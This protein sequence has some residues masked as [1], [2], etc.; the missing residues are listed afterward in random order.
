MTTNVYL[1]NV[2]MRQTS[3]LFLNPF[4]NSKMNFFEKV[5]LE[6]SIKH[7]IRNNGFFGGWLNEDGILQFDCVKVFTN[8]DEAIEFGRSQNQRAI[9]HIDEETEIRL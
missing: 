3:S 6:K 1:C 7:A 2:I 9:W 5:G 4:K 8:K